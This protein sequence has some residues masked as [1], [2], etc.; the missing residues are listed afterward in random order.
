MQMNCIRV[1]PAGRGLKTL[2]LAGI[3]VPLSVAAVHAEPLPLPYR[4]EP[5]YVPMIDV[6]GGP[7]KG[8]ILSAQEAITGREVPITI[9]NTTFIPRVRRNGQTFGGYTRVS[10]DLQI[11]DGDLYLGNQA[12]GQSLDQLRN[13]YSQQQLQLQQQGS[14]IERL[15]VDTDRNTAATTSLGGSVNQLE[16]TSANHSVRLQ[17]Q[18]DT[19]QQ[20]STTLQQH[21]TTLQQHALAI[22]DLATDVG[23][24]K[25]AIAR[26]DQNMSRLGSGISGAT[27]L[28]A[29]LGSL[30]VE[31][32][33]SP[34]A[35][36]IGTGGYSSRY[37]LAM[38]CAVRLSSALSLN[39]GGSYLFGGSSDYGSGVLSNVAGRIGL[40]Y[41]F[42][43]G[44]AGR[45]AAMATS[46]QANRQLQNQLQEAEQ[47]QE[48]MAADL[49]DLQKRLAQLE[50]VALL[51]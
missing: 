47:R 8:L 11:V 49:R 29:A 22:N 1:A 2:M 13:D 41:R 35:C 50:S 10:G 51:R 4:P 9:G 39:G 21:S 40:V 44:A 20:H 12:V 32:S 42:G 23:Q 36:G 26:L 28:A 16:R 38:G 34:V 46:Q 7:R 45:S 5:P 19:L 15:R 27:A 17:Q 3:S 31:S 37:A 6:F 25:Q 18:A 48:Q 24:S 14:S 33:E 43:S 30:P